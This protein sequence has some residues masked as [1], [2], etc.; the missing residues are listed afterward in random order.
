M[1]K[2]IKIKLNKEKIKKIFFNIVLKLKKYFLILLNYLKRFIIFL[3]NK[4][5]IVL[6]FIFK[7]LMIVIK[8]IFNNLK[9][10]IL[11]IYPILK[12]VILKIINYINIFTEK[13]YLSIEKYMPTVKQYINKIKKI[14]H[15]EVKEDDIDNVENIDGSVS[16]DSFVKNNLSEADKKAIEIALLEIKQKKEKQKKLINKI[17]SISFLIV[18]VILIMRL[19]INA[20][21]SKAEY[22]ALMKKTQKVVVMDISQELTGSGTLKPKDS[23]TITSLVEGEVIE[24]NFEEGEKVKKDQLLLVIDSKTAY[25]NINNASSSLAQA[26]ENYE[27][28]LYEYE[29]ILNRY[30][31]NTYKSEFSGYLRELKIKKGDIIS[32][33]TEIGTIVDDRIMSLKVPF[34][35][36][37]A[38]MIKQGMRA[39]VFIQE[40]ADAIDGVVISVAKEERVL[41][42]GM[43]VSYATIECVNPGGLTTDNT[44]IVTVNGITSVEDSNFY[45]KTE[46]KIIFQDGNNVEIE[47][48]ILNE[49]S[50]VEKDSP[51]FRI[52]EKSMN[53]VLSSKKNSYLSANESLIRA[54]TN[55]DDAVDNYDEYYIKAP[56]SGTVINKNVKV[57]DKIQRN[58][59]QT[60]TLAIIYDLSELTIDMDVDELDI[61]KVNVDQSVIINADAF[62]NKKFDGKVT[63]INLVANN[64]NGVS[65]YPVTVSI[66]KIGDLLPGM[67][68][69][70]TIVLNKAEKALCIPANALQR[71]NVVY[72]LNSS[73]TIKEKK[74]SNKDVNERIKNNTPKGFTAIPVKTAVSNDN[75]IQITEGLQEGDL[76][77]VETKNASM[78]FNMFGGQRGPMSGGPMNRR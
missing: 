7:Y 58:S 36:S 2:F 44:A 40:M 60:T 4:I 51:I 27:Q 47:E 49:G 32:N 59:S 41:N 37:E 62:S 39:T 31:D 50:Y 63:K 71:G 74:Y 9:I 34:V 23:Y 33:N 3:F 10:I 1:I 78:N 73:K 69:D 20:K 56:I 54:Q 28:S 68:V 64:S 14:L 66:E 15:I 72:V 38:N 77:Y 75:F 43:L 52:T 18:F 61:S 26:K 8:F 53:Y 22:E 46:E 30:S 45:V 35:S 6:I 12:K 42:G 70:A 19:I 17:V 29:K 67:N 11:F 16:S 76:V 25:R 55:Y 48:M 5:K 24:V 21:K 57:G 13:I 65:N